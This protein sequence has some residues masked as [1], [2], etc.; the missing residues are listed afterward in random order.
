[1]QKDKPKDRYKDAVE[2][3]GEGEQAGSKS[4]ALEWL[5]TKTRIID[6]WNKTMNETNRF[7][8]DMEKD[9]KVREGQDKR[10]YVHLAAHTH[11]DV[12][13]VKTVEQYYSGTNEEVF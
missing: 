4:A 10:L 3:A 8:N 2:K 1:M 5:K 12:G 6:T 9:L 13:W 7:H 11:D